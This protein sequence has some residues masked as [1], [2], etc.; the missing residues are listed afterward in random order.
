MWCG[1]FVRYRPEAKAFFD[2]L[3]VNPRCNGN[4]IRSYLIMPVQRI[5]RYRL[6]AAVRLR[7]LGRVGVLQWQGRS[8]SCACLA[9]LQELLKRTPAEHDDTALLKDAGE[10]INEVAMKLNA[11]AREQ[12]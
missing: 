9:C 7:V 5:P 3:R 12:E 8:R 10:R 11:A 4:T 2:N 1:A 6:L